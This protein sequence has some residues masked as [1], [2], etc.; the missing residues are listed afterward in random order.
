MTTFLTSAIKSGIE[1][2]FTMSILVKICDEPFF[3]PKLTNYFRFHFLSEGS[4]M[5]V[6][7]KL[8]TAVSYQFCL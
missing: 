3:M 5:A 8:S 7:F 6:F 1:F 2:S 4:K